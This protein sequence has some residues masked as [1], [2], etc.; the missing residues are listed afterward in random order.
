[1]GDDV[2]V[3]EIDQQNI[4]NFSVLAEEL[5]EVK[6]ELKDLEQ[7]KVLL[8]DVEDEVI[9]T[10]HLRAGEGMLYKFGDVYVEMEDARFEEVVQSEKDRVTK[11]ITELAARAEEIHETLSRLKAELYGRFRNQIALEME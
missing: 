1:M 11:K 4:C 10:E 5:R 7:D 2:T 9:L 8:G 3:R 6:R